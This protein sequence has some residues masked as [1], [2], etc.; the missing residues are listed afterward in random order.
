MAE[1]RT[2]D[3]IESAFFTLAG[4]HADG[5]MI[6]LDSMFNNERD[7]VARFALKHRLPTMVLTSEMVKSGGLISYGADFPDIFRR[8]AGYGGSHS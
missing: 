6:M 2:P 7:I 8:A 5:V 1:A 3:D 4:G